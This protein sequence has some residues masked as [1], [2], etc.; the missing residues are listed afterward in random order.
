MDRLKFTELEQN[1]GGYELW[2]MGQV[3]PSGLTFHSKI[4][5]FVGFNINTNARS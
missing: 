4:I 3:E 2:N 5:S 1:Q